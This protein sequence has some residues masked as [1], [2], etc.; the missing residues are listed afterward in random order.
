MFKSLGPDVPGRVLE[1]YLKV[2]LIP[3]GDDRILFYT[4]PVP[5]VIENREVSRHKGALAWAEHQYYKFEKVLRESERGIGLRVRQVWE[6][7]HRRTSPDEAV[8][9]TLRLAETIELFSPAEMTSQKAKESWSHY[10]SAKRRSHTL[11]LIVDTIISPSTLL[12]MP[13]PGPNV[14]GYWFVYRAFCH[15]LVLLG[16]RK[17]RDEIERMTV[18]HEEMLGELLNGKNEGKI[19]DLSVKYELRGLAGFISRVAA[20]SGDLSSD[21]VA[22]TPIV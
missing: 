19:S 3:L 7:L 22:A 13:L 18:H 14:V 15:I 10:I 17:A 16:I 9:R 8:L 1:Y 21:S 4:E 20:S 5:T 11:W 12:L 6:W 2:F